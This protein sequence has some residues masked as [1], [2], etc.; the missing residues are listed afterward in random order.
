[1]SFSASWNILRLKH[2]SEARRSAELNRSLGIFKPLNISSL[3]VT[4]AYQKLDELE[5]VETFSEKQQICNFLLKALPILKTLVLEEVLCEP[6]HLSAL[7]VLSYDLVVEKL[8]AEGRKSSD[9]SSTLVNELAQV[10]ELP[11]AALDTDVNDDE[12]DVQF[13]CNVCKYIL[14][15]TRRS[16]H[17]CKGF[18]LCEPCYSKVGR[19]HQHKMKRHRKL[20]VQTLLDLVESIRQVLH[21]HEQDERKEATKAPSTSRKRDRKEYKEEQDPAENYDEEVIECICGNNKDLGFMIS[22]EK[23]YAWL[24]GKCVGISKRNEPEVYYCPRCVKKPVTI[25]AKLSPKDVT[26]EEKL[27]E[28]GLS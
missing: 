18:D 19:K 25:N 27:K 4:G 2:I 20:A 21:E 28:Y 13:S 23:C 22:C 6:L 24:H 10:I 26:P 17:Q 14:F 7:V 12:E 9:L 16:C 11:L 3:L 15:N 1:M 8:A 5:V